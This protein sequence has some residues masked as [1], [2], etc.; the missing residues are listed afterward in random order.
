MPFFF[1]FLLLEISS[2]LAGVE[3]STFAVLD[4]D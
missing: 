1:F 3:S 2:S 4:D